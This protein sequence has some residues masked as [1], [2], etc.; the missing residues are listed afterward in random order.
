MMGANYGYQPQPHSTE[1]K[2]Y[3][4]FPTKTTSGK[5]LWFRDYWR[6]SIRNSGPFG[7]VR[8]DN[9][10]MNEKEYV[11]YMMKTP[12]LNPRPPVAKSGIYYYGKF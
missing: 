12:K 2:K 8:Y 4:W 9:K 7:I 11:V 1:S 3:A 5:W 6:V 10:I